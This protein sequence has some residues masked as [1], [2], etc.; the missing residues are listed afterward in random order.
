MLLV[1]Y[2][3]ILA[4]YTIF[5]L[6]SQPT[7]TRPSFRVVYRSSLHFIFISFLAKMLISVTFG[8]VVW[9]I[10]CCIRCPGSWGY[11]FNTKCSASGKRSLSY[12]LYY[13]HTCLIIRYLMWHFGMI[14]CCQ[15]AGWAHH[16]LP[17]PQPSWLLFVSSGCWSPDLH[18]E[19]Q[20]HSED[21]CCDS[22]IGVELLGCLPIHE[23]CS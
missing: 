18:A 3:G 5:L 14:S 23:R 1:F 16:L 17:K 2:V 20:C 9:S 15:P 8:F 10:C 19:G 7:S 12:L 22:H 21:H 13:M 11:N 4:C 6:S